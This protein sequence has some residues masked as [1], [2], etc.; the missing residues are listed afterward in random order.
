MFHFP[1]F[2]PPLSFKLSSFLVFPYFSLTNHWYMKISNYW[3][4]LSKAENQSQKGKVFVQ[5]NST[6]TDIVGDNKVIP[7]VAVRMS[8]HVNYLIL[9]RLP[10]IL[11]SGY[12]CT[13]VLPGHTVFR[14]IQ[15]T[16]YWYARGRII[17][18]S[19]DYCEVLCP[20]KSYNK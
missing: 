19:Y 11:I 4:T 6:G 15:W 10:N 17:S 14:Y 18:V 20:A 13:K 9:V 7:V 12:H 1:I 2:S 16:A 8:N 3:M 5:H